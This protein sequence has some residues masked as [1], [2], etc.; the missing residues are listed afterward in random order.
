MNKFIAKYCFYYPTTLVKGEFIFLFNKFY[1]R[2]QRQPKKDQ[3]DY[4]L[5]KLNKVLLI[6]KTESEFYKKSLQDIKLPLSS[7]EEI[8]Q[9]PLLTKQHLIANKEELKTWRSFYS[10][11]KT[12]GGSTGEPVTL[13]KNPEALARERAATWRAYS[14]AGVG[15]GDR[16]ARFWG[17]PHSKSGAFKARIIDF[18]S[19]RK[20]VS[21]FNLTE[22]SMLEYYRELQEFQP[23]YLYG[24]VSVIR[25]LSAFLAAKNLAPIASIKS[26]I[27]T[28]EILTD[29]A[30]AEITSYWKLPIFNEYGCGEVGSIAHECQQGNMHLM[31]DNLL[32]E[33][34]DE[35][36]K[37]SDTG[38][39]VVTDFYNFSTPIIRYKLGDFATL[40]HQK[41]SC[42]VTLPLI[43]NIHGRAYDL[44]K[45]SSGKSIHPEALIY[46]FEDLQI[47]HSGFS[48]FQIV[49]E[50]LEELTVN[51]IRTALWSDNLAVLIQQTVHQQISND[52]NCRF[53]YVD[54]ISREKSGKMRV[55]K[56]LLR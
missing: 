30:R 24:Y 35:D 37:P 47:K 32:V 18:I 6:A 7:L 54:A 5:A 15:V 12:T 21:A 11:A 38:E 19:N 28:S 16:Q 43:S 39:I 41:C 8:S 52:I 36:G 51:I 55:V 56:S 27:T 49:Q 48:Q 9:L 1:D 29:G 53:N 3:D 34:I 33:C 10:S 23:L 44:I 42:G 14:W 2:F 22:S 25:A 13:L 45:T 31:S 46:I 40:S 50:S 20:R 4:R 26:I 17:V